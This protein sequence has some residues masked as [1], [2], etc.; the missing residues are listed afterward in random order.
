MRATL[1]AFAACLV[2]A[3]AG[4]GGDGGDDGQ[5][6]FAANVNA[7]CTEYWPKLALI[8]PPAEDVDEW[9]AIGADLG[10][11]LEA[12]ANELRLLEPPPGVN[13]EYAEWLTL[14]SELAAAMREVQSAGGL[15]DEAGV[16]AGLEQIETTIEEADALAEE[17]GF[18]E[19]SP[20]QIQTA[21]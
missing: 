11:L 5:A 13:D 19:C 8:P 12:S 14:R 21:R 1:G 9:A 10:D 18:D 16:A 6:E 3:V 15:H 20:T 7:V 4:C 17:L 2:L